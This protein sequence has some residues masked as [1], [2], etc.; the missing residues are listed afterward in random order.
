M[1]ISEKQ[2]PTP[3]LQRLTQYIDLVH[4]LKSNGEKWISSKTIAQSLGLTSSTV[5]QDLSHI[6]LSGSVSKHGYKLGD[7]QHALTTSLG[8]D[9]IRHA[10]VIGAGN[11]GKALALHEEFPRRGFIICGIFDSDPKKAGK[12]AGALTIKPMSTLKAFIHQKPVDIGIIA[13]PS[14]A[15]Q[16]VADMLILN[17]VPGLLNLAP[18]HIV[19]PKGICVVN[20]RIVT[21][22]RELSHR[23]TLTKRNMK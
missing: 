22:L 7:L 18:G 20:S 23:I 10:V 11:L 16:S 17:G 14:H 9:V 5:R 8:A 6:A 15:A 21:S 12:K 19:V 1:N 2:L 13:V 3:V 4:M